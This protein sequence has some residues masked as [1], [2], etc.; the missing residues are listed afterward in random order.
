M[1][2][3]AFSTSFA[4][5]GDCQRL[6]LT[7][8]GPGVTVISTPVCAEMGEWAGN[9]GDLF[10]KPGSKRA[11][12]RGVWVSQGRI[13]DDSYLNVP[14]ANSGRRFAC[15]RGAIEADPDSLDKP[16]LWAG[17]EPV[18]EL[19]PEGMKAGG[20]LP[21]LM[22]PKFDYGLARYVTR[23]VKRTALAE[24]AEAFNSTV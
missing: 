15:I 7:D 12:L 4:I 13:S 21:R 24:A 1:E 3:D 10:R 20:R 9:L 11:R 17:S 8:C 2:S 18:R 22:I 5:Y 16:S 19:R 6:K 23:Q 14:I